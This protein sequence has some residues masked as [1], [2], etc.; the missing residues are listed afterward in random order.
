[1]TW[2]SDRVVLFP[3]HHIGVTK[4]KALVLF[5]FLFLT[6][7]VSAQEGYVIA[8][9]AQL[10]A[11]PSAKSKI[12]ATLKIGDA[13]KVINRAGTWRKV[14]NTNG[15]G[16]LDYRAVTLGPRPVLPSVAE[17]RPVEPPRSDLIL[18]KDIEK[19]IRKL[20][21]RGINIFVVDA[22]V[23]LTGTVRRDRFANVMK[24]AM[25]NDIRQVNNK[26]IVK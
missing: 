13:I 16:W 6:V 5:L 17:T 7:A 18:K 10:R 15:I 22:V 4:M 8:E 2:F 25:Q 1:M 20:G 9:P 3:G 14:R 11:A 21:E 19:E 12:V 24:A 23:T 26:L